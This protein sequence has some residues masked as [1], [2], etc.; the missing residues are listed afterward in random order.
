MSI[1]YQNPE[2]S[3]EKLVFSTNLSGSNSFFSLDYSL[4]VKETANNLSNY[5]GFAQDILPIDLLNVLSRIFILLEKLSE[6]PFD[7]NISINMAKDKNLTKILE[8]LQNYLIPMSSKVVI[9]NTLSEQMIQ[10]DIL[11]AFILAES[12]IVKHFFK[13]KRYETEDEG[14][15]GED[16]EYIVQKY[17]LVNFREDATHPENA[18]NIY[19]PPIVNEHNFKL[20]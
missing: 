5:L 11:P 12:H 16:D 15:I 1:V 7:E 6:S 9:N 8:I 14:K 19:L 18:Q 20:K 13:I 10:E 17:P 4:T 2:L 3:Y